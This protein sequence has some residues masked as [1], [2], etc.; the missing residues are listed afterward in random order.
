M[1]VHRRSGRPAQAGG[2]VLI[3]AA[4]VVPAVPSFQLD[5]GFWYSIPEAQHPLVGVG[6]LVRVPLGGR[7]VR[8]FVVELTD[9]SGEGL[10]PLAAVSMAPPIFDPP[11]LAAL[12]WAAHRYV[13]PLA[14]LLERAAPPNLVGVLPATPGTEVRLGAKTNHPLADVARIVAAGKRRPPVA[15]IERWTNLE[16][17]EA[18][19]AP[20]TA[21]GRTLMIIAATSD[22]VGVLHESAI[23][24]VGE[25]RSLVV[26]P[27]RSDAENTAAWASAQSGGNVVVGTPR[28]AAWRVGDLGLGVVVEEGRRAMKDRQTPTIH[29]RDLLRTRAQLGRHTLAF[30]GPTPSLETLAA[31]A[32]PMRRTRRAWPPVEVVDRNSQPPLPGLLS[33]PVLAAI[34]AITAGGGS[35]FVFAHRRGYAPAVRCERC[36]TVRQCPNCGSRPE[37]APLCPRCSYQLGPCSTCGHDRFVPLGAGV[38]RVLEELK[39]AGGLQVS[40]APEHGPVMV[41]S[42]ADLA[43]LDP[44]D[45]AVAVD[46]DGLILGTHFRAAEEAL[47]ILARLAGRVAAGGGHRAMIQTSLPEHP[48]IDALRRGDPIPFLQL[49]LEERRAL[50]FPPN[51]DLVVVE[52]RG[53]IPSGVNTGLH[54]AADRAVVLGPAARREGAQ[55]WLIQGNDLTGFRHNLRPLVQRWRD[56]GATVRIDSDPLEL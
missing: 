22:E 26:G 34:R 18:I 17:V 23:S 41:G 44:V 31:G 5:S 4:R 50:G 11:L 39:R 2:I 7:R 53:T 36:R 8:G 37:A 35:A 6:S 3:R 52:L 32:T 25:E 43:G 1:G 49:E 45:L 54:E 9:R 29:A 30:V 46:A 15:L 10:K 13:A 12:H 16:W 38:G 47:R 19:A 21:A 55:R 20:V 14:V 33:H 48:V 42:E 28:L 51:G 27:D 24:A 40:A 56:A